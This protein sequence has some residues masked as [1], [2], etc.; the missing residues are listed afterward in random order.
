[1]ES[2]PVVVV[3]RDNVVFASDARD[4]G[5]SAVQR[6]RLSRPLV[7]NP[8]HSQYVKPP[9]DWVSSQGIFPSSFP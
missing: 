9:I 3:L 4:V 6:Q 7:H 8:L 2:A 1:M 5:V